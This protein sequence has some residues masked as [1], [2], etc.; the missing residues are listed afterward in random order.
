MASQGTKL[1]GY[2]IITDYREVD[3]MVTGV[4]WL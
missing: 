3:M 2:Q 4:F 1:A